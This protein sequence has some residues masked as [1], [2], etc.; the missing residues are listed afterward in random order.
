MSSLAG[1]PSADGSRPG[2]GTH[3]LS[4]G[5]QPPNPSCN[6]SHRGEP[7]G[8]FSSFY[9]SALG[10]LRDVPLRLP[11]ALGA[12]PDSLVSVL[13]VGDPLISPELGVMIG[14]WQGEGEGRAIARA[15]G[16]QQRQPSPSRRD[17]TAPLPLLSLSFGPSY[18]PHSDSRSPH[19]TGSSFSQC[20][21]KV[22]SM[23]KLP[24]LAFRFLHELASTCLSALF[25]LPFTRTPRAL[26]IWMATH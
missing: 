24:I 26:S 22:C 11:Q 12:P 21:S 14:L 20:C 15:P 9:L 19:D 3:T 10:P 5:C 23:T 13:E 2:M 18:A 8:P 17:G 7:G 16:F 4:L 1:V 6:K 25:P